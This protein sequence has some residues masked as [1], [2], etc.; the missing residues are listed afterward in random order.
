MSYVYKMM[1]Q[2]KIY[3]RKENK[4]LGLTIIILFLIISQIVVSLVIIENSDK[5][6]LN[7]KQ[8]R[9]E[10]NSNEGLFNKEKIDDFN[11]DDITKYKSEETKNDYTT[12][13]VSLALTSFGSWP[14]Y[15][16]GELKGGP[17]AGDIDGDGYYEIVVGTLNGLIRVYETDGTESSNWSGG[18]NIGVAITSTPMLANIDNNSKTEEIIVG[19]ASGSVYAF[20]G[21]GSLIPGWPVNCEGAVEESLAVGDI[22]GNGENEIVIG[23][24]SSKVYAFNGD[25]TTV[26]GWPKTTGGGV[27]VAPVLADVDNDNISDI[28]VGSTDG[29]VYVWKGNG[30]IINSFPKDLTEPITH[31]LTVADID[32]D[33]DIDIVCPAGRNLYLL[34]N[35]GTIIHS[36][37]TSSS[38]ADSEWLGPIIVDI[39]WDRE[40]EIIAL[41]KK[42]ELKSFSFSGDLLTDYCEDINISITMDPIITDIDNDYNWE[43]LY[44]S[45]LEIY[46]RHFY[47]LSMNEKLLSSY[48]DISGII[49]IQGE[50]LFYTDRSGYIL[51]AENS[52][53]T[54]YDWSKINYNTKNNRF[55]SYVNYYTVASGWP[56]NGSY[57]RDIA[58]A[59]I[60]GD[61]ELEIIAGYNGGITIFNSDGTIIPGWPKTTYSYY[62]LAV[63]D[64][65]GDKKLEIVAGYNGGITIFNSDGTIIPGWPKSVDNNCRNLVVADVDGDTE[66]E[67]IAGYTTGIIIFNSD[68][69]IIPG[70]PKTEHNYYSLAVADTDGDTELEIIAGYNGGIT[71]FNSDGTIIPGWPKS[72]SSKNYNN[73]AVADIDG[74]TELEIITG[75]YGGVTVFNGDGTVVSG[76]PA[77]LGGD[78]LSLAVADIDGDTELEIIAGYWGGLTIFNSDGTVVSGWPIN[79]YCYFDSLAVVDIDND[80]ELEIIAIQNTEED[81]IFHGKVT[82]FNGDGTVVSGWPKTVLGYCLSLAIADVDGDTELEIIGGFVGEIYV[83]NSIGK[84]YAP[85]ITQ[86]VNN[87][88]TGTFLD[89]DNDGLFDQEEELLHADPTSDDT[90]NDGLTDGEEVKVYSTSPTSVDTDNDSLTDGD[91]VKVYSTSPT[92]VDTDNDGLTDGDEIKGYFTNPTVKD[93]D[94]DG[95]FDGYEVYSGLNPLIDDSN[96]DLDDDGLTNLEE[97]NLG[98]C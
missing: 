47:S 9:L 49:N 71:I 52:H 82:V 94:S 20:F 62:S 73:L 64:I 22:D 21:N 32:Q 13:K 84:G 95:M 37:Q 12:D 90:D 18:K 34:A 88:R 17:G 1:K 54:V 19:T 76:W 83:W 67:I 74:D 86:S 66:L 53:H 16:G 44:S 45:S 33:G 78:C 79:S 85:L 41:T 25:G 69:T 50:Y 46:S 23:S 48:V 14:I 57:Y 11:L 56:K 8:N 27:I 35:N 98:T 58:I 68:G 31:P 70:W 39:N 6:I 65:D 24:N 72:D 42:G 26:S 15:V 40:Y 28:I 89:T 38:T 97:F 51:A 81:M 59:D 96:S 2:T 92:S 63:A 30:N 29:K 3:F 91:E 61:T 55:N 36:W 80:L 7:F 4:G 75:Y 43:L 5:D 77:N 10:K 87:Q 93:S 60:D